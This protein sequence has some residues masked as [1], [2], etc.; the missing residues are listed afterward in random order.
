MTRRNV[1]AGDF[2]VR[3]HGRS[4]HR[5]KLLDLGYARAAGRFGILNR[6]AYARTRKAR[7]FLRRSL[8]G[9]RHDRSVCPAPVQDDAIERY[10]GLIE[11][12]FERIGFRER[13]GG[14]FLVQPRNS[15]TLTC[16]PTA[17]QQLLQP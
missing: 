3:V 9:R 15:S 6:Q 14:K 4:Q 12:L 13:F 11:A 16:L 1:I 10:R 17:A 8:R 7:S 5:R 2:D